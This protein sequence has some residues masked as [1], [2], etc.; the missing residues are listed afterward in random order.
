MGCIG[1]GGYM[2]KVI[3]KP[4]IIQIQM[5][6]YLPAS[7]GF[8]FNPTKFQELLSQEILDSRFSTSLSLEICKELI[9]S[10]VFLGEWKNNFSYTYLSHLN[11]I[12]IAQHVTLKFGSELRLTSVGFNL[13]IK[14]KFGVGKI[15]F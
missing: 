12:I 4:F 14:F 1:Q 8:V 5:S 10:R 9:L 15:I 13:S 3:R 6:L 11:Q 7:L 2:E